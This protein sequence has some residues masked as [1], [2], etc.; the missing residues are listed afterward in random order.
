MVGDFLY[1]GM[2]KYYN[3]RGVKVGKVRAEGLFQGENW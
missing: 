3:K 2:L 1:S